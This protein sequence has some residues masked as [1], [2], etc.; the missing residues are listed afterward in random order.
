MTAS[1]AIA[2]GATAST[3]TLTLIKGALKLMAWTKSKTAIVSGAVILLATFSAVTVASHFHRISPRLKL[4]TGHGTPTIAY[5]YSRYVVTLASDGSLWSWGEE[6]LGWP[7]LGLKDTKIQNTTSLRRIGNGTDW[8]SVAVGD[9]HCLAIKSD[10]SL[11]AWGANFSYQLGDGTKTTRPIPVP[12][13]PG[14]DWK[15]AAAGGESSFAVKN[16]GT[17]WTWGYRYPGNGSREENASAVQV[18][19]STNWGKIWTGRI[20]RE[21]GLQSDGSLWFKGIADG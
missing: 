16:D 17:L 2:K 8:V 1:V 20:Q 7:V 4:P 19:V 13:V 18:G 5:G 21:V 12:S 9:S 6:R 3:S 10:G 15:Q 11:W 14:N